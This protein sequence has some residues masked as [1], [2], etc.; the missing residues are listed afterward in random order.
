M[1]S[2]NTCKNLLLQEDLWK[3]TSKLIYLHASQIQIFVS[4]IDK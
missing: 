1:S 3:I 4:S 2:R